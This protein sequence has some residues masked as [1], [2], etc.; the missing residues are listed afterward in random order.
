M[1]LRRF[2]CQK[3]FTWGKIIHHSQSRVNLSDLYGWKLRSAQLQSRYDDNTPFL[4]DITFLV[5]ERS[6][7]IKDSG[8]YICV[9]FWSSLN[10]QAKKFH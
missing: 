10:D 8:L 7:G 5:I 6:G 4:V 1:G 9:L 3:G 2:V